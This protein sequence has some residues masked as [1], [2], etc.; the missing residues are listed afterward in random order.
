MTA[1]DGPAPAQSLLFFGCRNEESDFF[2]RKRWE[3]FMAAGVLIP[4]TG[5]V[6]AFSRDQPKKVYVQ[7]KIKEKSSAVWQ[8]LQQV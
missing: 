5:L 8:L 3:E 1:G 4:E 2:Y 6:P 7:D